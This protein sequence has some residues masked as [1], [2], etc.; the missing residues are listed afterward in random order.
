V[1]Y[2]TTIASPVG[3]LMLVSDGSAL[4][5]LLFADEHGARLEDALR[6]SGN[7]V[8]SD[9]AVPLPEARRE[10]AEYFAGRRRVFAIPL[11]LRGTPFQKRVWEA[12]RRI[13]YGATTSYR[14]IARAVG[15]PAAMRAVGAANGSNRLA[16]VVP[17]HRVIGADGTLTGYGG[18]L[19]RK[20]ALL[21]LEAAGG[22]AARTRSA[23]G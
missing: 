19:A 10:L 23:T 15:S 22:R 16:I 9:E 5:A 14:E 1:N 6:A 3:S 13:P 8:A 18:G 4:T 12:L 2:T 21:D 20:H 11:A 7:I 17:C